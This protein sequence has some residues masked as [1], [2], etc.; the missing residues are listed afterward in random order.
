MT[1]HCLSSQTKEYFKAVFDG[2]VGNT[3]RL[4]YQMEQDMSNEL[5][6][7][8]SG[9]VLGTF[10]AAVVFNFFFCSL[11]PPDVIS[12]ELCIPKGGS[13]KSNDLSPNLLLL[14]LNLTLIIQRLS[15]FYIPHKV[16]SRTPKDVFAYP[17]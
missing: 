7:S 4:I 8:S 17:K 9:L 13:P 3:E 10:S 5:D 11:T 16:F 12:L 14:T 6:S 1:R 15:L 2:G